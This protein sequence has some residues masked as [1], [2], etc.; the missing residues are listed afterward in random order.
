MKLVW[1]RLTLIMLTLVLAFGAG[2]LS[3][4]G[5]EE[6]VAYS[7]TVLAPDGTPVEGVGVRWGTSDPVL[8]D[9]EG[10][11][12]ALLPP[13][14]YPISLSLLPAGYSDRSNSIVSAAAPDKTITLSGSSEEEQIL[15]TVKVLDPEGNPVSGLRIEL[16]LTGDSGA[17]FPFDNATDEKGETSRKLAPDSYHGKIISGLNENWTYPQDGQGYYTAAIADKTNPMLTI[18]LTTRA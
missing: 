1:K 13:K 7:V 8:T 14:N 18:Q 15:Y 4:C 3:A 5:E 10:V 17:C 2:V 16:C 6:T 12:T 11:A 9:S